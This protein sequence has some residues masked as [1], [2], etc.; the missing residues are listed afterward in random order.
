MIALLRS[1]ECAY[2]S[3]GAIFCSPSC[4]VK[5][6]EVEISEAGDVNVVQIGI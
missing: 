1:V 5:R 4:G 2:S 6:Q 3:T